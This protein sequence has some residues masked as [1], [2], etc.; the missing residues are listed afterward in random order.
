MNSLSNIV[1]DIQTMSTQ[2]SKQCPNCK[3]WF[4]TLKSFKHHIRHCRRTNCKATLNDL[5]DSAANPLQS[6]FTS[7]V[8]TKVFQQSYFIQLYK[9]EYED[10]QKLED[11]VDSTFD[12][13]SWVNI[14]EELKEDMDDNTSLI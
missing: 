5:R 1:C 6:N 4:T 13:D 7:G 3:L 9:D 8:E 2:S 11:F 12:S 10:F 14:D